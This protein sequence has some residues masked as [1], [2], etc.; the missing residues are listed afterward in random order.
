MFK[1]TQLTNFREEFKIF[2]SICKVHVTHLPLKSLT[3]IYKLN[4]GL[5]FEKRFETFERK[6]DPWG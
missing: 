6:D 5:K 4:I 3:V 1:I 2:L